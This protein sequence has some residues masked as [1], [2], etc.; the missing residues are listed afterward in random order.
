MKTPP[1]FQPDAAAA[2]LYAALL[3]QI[4]ALEALAV[5]AGRVIRPRG[6]R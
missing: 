3:R 2:A 1:W 5:R 6:E 4:R